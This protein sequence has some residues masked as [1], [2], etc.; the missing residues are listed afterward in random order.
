MIWSDMD[1]DETMDR[2]IDDPYAARARIWALESLL[3]W[4]TN[5]DEPGIKPEKFRDRTV[6]WIWEHDAWPVDVPEH[7]IATFEEFT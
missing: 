3:K 6:V 7:L 5:G 1:Y 4:L 2:I